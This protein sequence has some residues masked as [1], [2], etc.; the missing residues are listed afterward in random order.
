MFETTCTNLYIFF[1]IDI[2]GKVV[3]TY[4][5]K[6]PKNGVNKTILDIVIE[7]NE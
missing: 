7:D 1:Y 2:M 5:P 3:F 6:T 4:E